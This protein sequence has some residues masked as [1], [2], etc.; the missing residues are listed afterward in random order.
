MRFAI[1]VPCYGDTYGDPAVLCSLA[2]EA[3]A[4]G[5]DGFFMWDH[6]VAQPLVA[7]PWVTLGAVAART[8]RI[9]LGPMITPVPRRRPWKLA[10]EASTLQRLSSGRLVLGVGMGVPRDYTSFGEPSDARSRAARFSEGVELVQE[11]LSG[12]PVEHRGEVFEVSGVRF[13][14]VEVPVWTSGIW[15]RKVPFLAAARASGLFPIIQDG[16][17]GFAVASP[18]Q[19]ARMKADF[20]AA[21]GP[22]D[23]D[24]AIWG[25]GA[26]PSAAE[27][28]EYADAGATWL[29]LDGWKA[30]LEELRS[31][32]SAGPPR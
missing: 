4:A 15:P 19:A 2:V 20:V 32:V 1:Y 17:G 26:R 11:L 5:W 21:G 16:S 23:G 29:L 8:S 28:S 3:E 7:D 22:A 18:E 6:V 30:S 24:L 12:E 31:Y 10:L 25:G 13:A 27:V 14:P 9:A